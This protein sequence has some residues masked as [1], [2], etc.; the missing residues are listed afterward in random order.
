[1]KK[2]QT[3]P[4]RSENREN[5]I[6]P[7]PL[8][9]KD[10]GCNFENYPGMLDE[11][12]EWPIEFLDLAFKMFSGGVIPAGKFFSLDRKSVRHKPADAGYDRPRNGSDQCGKQ[13]AHMSSEKAANY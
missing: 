1:M 2:R 5:S 4:S 11:S 8:A 6:C 10:L 7:S 12:E 13:R 3:S 9:G